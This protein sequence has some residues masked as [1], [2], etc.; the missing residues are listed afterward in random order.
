MSAMT[1]E[2][3]IQNSVH[4]ASGD[5][6]LPDG[7]W[8]MN[9]SG[10]NHCHDHAPLVKHHGD[11]SGVE[12]HHHF[13]ETVSPPLPLMSEASEPTYL[14]GLELRPGKTQSLNGLPPSALD[15]PPRGW[16]FL[17]R[18]APSVWRSQKWFER[19]LQ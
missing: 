12:H 9:C 1:V 14:F 16:L 8:A 11:H 3:Q 10:D 15:Q 13:S 18:I 17:T 5:V 2:A 19:N 4:M 6:F 7:G